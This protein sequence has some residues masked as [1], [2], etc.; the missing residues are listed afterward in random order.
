ML[1]KLIDAVD[2]LCDV[3]VG[4]LSDD[5]LHSTVVELRRLRCSRMVAVESKL[6]TEWDAR[7]MWADD[8]SRSAGARLARETGANPKACNAAMSRARALRTMPLTVTALAHGRVSG[9]KAAALCRVNTAAAR[10]L[11]AE[12][13][14]DLL[15]KPDQFGFDDFNRILRYWKWLADDAT[16]DA[17]ARRQFDERS[18]NA[19]RTFAGGVHGAFYLPA[20]EGTIVKDELDRLVD[21]EYQIDLAKTTLE[22]GDDAAAHLPRTATQRKADAVIAM[23]SRSASLRHGHDGTERLPLFTV[24]VGYETLTERV[25]ETEDGTMIHPS[26]I[27]RWFERAEVERIVFDGPNRVTEVGRRTRTFRGALRRAIQVRDR[28]C[29]DPSGCDQ[30]MSSCE[31]DHII[32][33]ED[34]GQTTQANGQ[35]RCGPHNRYKHRTKRQRPPPDDTS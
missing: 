6:L 27:L 5:E 21:E 24:L 29:T 8:G 4:G 15:G 11:F 30:P 7:R 9:D 34:G 25:C 20:L 35:L 26:Q 32:E 10:E 14:A 18:A 2:E 1:G 22:W 28:H 17:R 33:Y 23:A 31:V 13:E 19:S 3:D 12:A 16:E